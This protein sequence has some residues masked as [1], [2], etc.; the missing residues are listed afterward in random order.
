MKRPARTSPP[1]HHP[2][3][4]AVIAAANAF[5]CAGPAHGRG[6][7]A[8]LAPDCEADA[9]WTGEECAPRDAV[10]LLVTGAQRDVDQLMLDEAQ[11]KLTLADDLA[12]P[13]AWNVKLWQ[14]RALRSAFAEDEPGAVAAYRRLLAMSPSYLLP[15]TLSPRATFPFEKARG[16]ID[17]SGGTDIRID[18]PPNARVGK[19]I[20]VDIQ[21]VADPEGILERGT[22]YVSTEP[23]AA[24][25]RRSTFALGKPGHTT[26]VILPALRGRNDMK[27]Q[28]YA[29]AHDARGN[30]VW[31]WSSRQRPRKVDV[32]WIAPTP[33]YRRWWVWAATGAIAAGAA[34]YLVYRS[35]VESP[36]VVD[37]GVS[38]R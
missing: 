5:A 3:L 31:Q 4:P 11:G 19:P 29:V 9:F 36:A 34:G 16:D 6:R 2:I 18:L 8:L 21:V 22:L 10:A 35:T 14:A 23:G 24:S 38:V 13:L 20:A 32:A 37:V 1:R 28:V 33:W 7:T 17:A 25:W 27:L 15:Y 26:H 30:E 12:K